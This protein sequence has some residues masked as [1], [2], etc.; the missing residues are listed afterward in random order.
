MSP[1]WRRTCTAMSRRNGRA[2]GECFADTMLHVSC[3]NESDCGFYRAGALLAPHPDSGYEHL[4]RA[5]LR[6]WLDL[7]NHK[8]ESGVKVPSYRIGCQ[9]VIQLTILNW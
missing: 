7:A 1:L 5:S 2:R 3:E 6:G 8:P 9:D 4:Q